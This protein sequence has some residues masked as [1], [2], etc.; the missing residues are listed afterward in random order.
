MRTLRPRN[1]GGDDS[2]SFT[3]RSVAALKP[4]AN[5]QRDVWDPGFPRFGLRITDRGRRVWVVRYR[6]KG[7][8]R[9]LTLGQYPDLT[10]ADARKQAR[11]VL[12]A[13]ANGKDPAAQK[14][15]DR[16]AET[17]GELA[18][19]Y[20]DRHAKP[21]KK[22]WREDERIIETELLPRW[23]H[24]KVRELTRREVRALLDTIAERPAPIMANRVLALVRKMMNFALEHDWIDANP[25]VK[26]PRPG[27]ERARDRVLTNDELRKVWTA[28]EAEPPLQQAF[29]KLRLLTAQRGG[30]LR[31]M[32]WTDV[33]LHS[34]WWTIPAEQA[35]NGLSHRV[36]L[37]P[38]AK[39]ILENLQKVTGESRWVFP[40]PMRSGPLV[41]I[42]KV[43]RNV[44]A[45]TGIAFRGHDL[46][47]TA[48]SRMAGSGVNRLVIA[49]V[50]NHAETGVTAVY[51]RHSYDAEKRTAL[52]GWARELEAILAEGDNETVARIVSFNRK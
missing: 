36:P 12:H 31:L 23:K 42:K 17:V 9:R 6:A 28:F 5:G 35:K 26:I 51:D 7:R 15:T 50:L 14:A 27:D 48:A 13:V 3:A 1:Q 38:T 16:L 34:A 24:R 41:E 22:S 19:E 45:G 44:Q 20:L 10:L 8:H 43:I 33:D 21:R 4:P 49:K 39:T 25:A 11:D 2:S 46:R 32:Q 18:T 40:S 30:E 52:D 47:R 29:C 37:S